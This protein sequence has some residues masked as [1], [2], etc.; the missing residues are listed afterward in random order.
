[1]S[2]HRPRHRHIDRETAEQLLHGDP[3]A[4]HEVG[5]LAAPL[6][7]A[8]A[9][10]SPDELVGEQMALAAFR[11]AQLVPVPLPRRSSMLKIAMAKVLTA[12]AAAVLAG[13]S[14]GG[15]AV[16]TTTGAIP[17]P[18]DNKPDAP[19]PA[20]S[21]AHSNGSDGAHPSP[22]LVGLCRAYAAGAT[23]NPGKAAENPAFAALV[24]AAKGAENIEEFC[25]TV[26]KAGPG[27]T[28]GA[29]DTAGKPD[30]LPVPPVTGASADPPGGGAPASV[31]SGPPAS[32]RR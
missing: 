6:A 5:P 23:D 2:T 18:F 14:L 11:A 21:P 1:M 31:P 7:A 16:A 15:V 3:G 26:D 30:D 13:L 25:E 9:A 24:S 32:P 8:R 10:A 22:S 12:K 29:P 28:P 27:A 19:A 20:A 17:T 4:L